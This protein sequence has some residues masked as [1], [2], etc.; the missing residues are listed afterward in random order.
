METTVLAAALGIVTL[1]IV[2]EARDEHY[3]VGRMATTM[4]VACASA[5]QAY[6]I[7]YAIRTDPFYLPW[8]LVITS[9]LLMC[10]TMRLVVTRGHSKPTRAEAYTRQPR[11]AEKLRQLE[12]Q[13][14]E[15]LAAYNLV[16][17]DE[18]L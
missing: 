6:F 2:G 14:K 16:L 18:G 13:K 11:L 10:Y 9:Q 17:S 15:K 8:P 12:E 5:L 7:R 4:V 3:R 1:W